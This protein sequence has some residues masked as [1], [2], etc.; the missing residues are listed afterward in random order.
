MNRTA[1]LLS[2]L[3][4]V[5]ASLPIVDFAQNPTPPPSAYGAYPANY[6]EIVTAWLNT[7]LD[8]PKSVLVKWLGEPKPTELPAATGQKI[9]GYLVEFTV[10]ARNRF[11]A[12]TGP[13]KHG[14]LI[15]DGEVVKATGFVYR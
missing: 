4:L 14:A 11:G 7:H 3:T 5:V 9:A 6:K 13:Q 2:I 1:K 12:Y 10:N 15:R 8:D